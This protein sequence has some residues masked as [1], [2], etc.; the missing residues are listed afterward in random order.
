MLYSISDIIVTVDANGRI[1]YCNPAGIEWLGFSEQQIQ[2]QFL[3]LIMS[4][5]PSKEHLSNWVHRALEFGKEHHGVA[6][7]SRLSSPNTASNVNI[8]VNPLIHNNIGD[9]GAMVILRTL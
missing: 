5:Y 2:G 9:K 1:D 3:E 4:S 7:I 6:T 8:Q